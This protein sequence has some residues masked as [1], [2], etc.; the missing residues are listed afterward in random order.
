IIPIVLQVVGVISAK[1]FFGMTFT[2]PYFVMSFVLYGTQIL[3]TLIAL[4]L[5]YLRGNQISHTSGSQNS[6]AMFRRSLKRILLFAIAPCLIQVPFA[7]LMVVRQINKSF[8][9]NET[10]SDMN[11]ILDYATQLLFAIKPTIDAVSTLLFLGE[12]RQ[13]LTAAGKRIAL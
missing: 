3:L 4:R 9:D 11:V 5:L 2:L 6:G 13:H 7:L 10:L 12:Y 8:P 1:R